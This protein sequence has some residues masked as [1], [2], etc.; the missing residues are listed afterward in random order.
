MLFIKQKIFSQI[1]YNIIYSEH[2]QRY[3]EKKTY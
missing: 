1:D 2:L 3:I